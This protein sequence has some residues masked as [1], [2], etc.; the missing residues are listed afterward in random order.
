MKDRDQ[1][2][3]LSHDPKFGGRH[4]NSGIMGQFLLLKSVKDSLDSGVSEFEKNLRIIQ[5]HF[6]GNILNTSVGLPDDSLLNLECFLIFSAAGEGQ[7]FRTPIEE[8]ETIGI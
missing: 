1:V 8:E 3:T 2:S 5:Q 7:K 4:L 6:I